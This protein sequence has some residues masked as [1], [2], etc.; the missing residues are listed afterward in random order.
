M[1]LLGLLAEKPVD[2]VRFLLD[3]VVPEVSNA[4]EESRDAGGAP[5][6]CELLELHEQTENKGF[7]W[8]EK[9]RFQNDFSSKSMSYLSG[10]GIFQAHK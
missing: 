1:L 2:Q 3:S 6:F 4:I 9:A 5:I 10:K 8:R 7:I